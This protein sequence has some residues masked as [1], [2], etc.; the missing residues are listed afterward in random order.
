VERGSTRMIFL[1]MAVFR[2]ELRGTVVFGPRKGTSML[3][4]ST[5][6]GCR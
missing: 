4:A 3:R 1:A 2:V 6:H 5:K